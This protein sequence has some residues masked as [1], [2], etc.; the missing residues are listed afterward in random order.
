MKDSPRPLAAA[1]MVLVR[2]AYAADLPTPDDA[3]QAGSEPRRRA[4]LR[5]RRPPSSR[6]A[7]APRGRRRRLAR[8]ARR[9]ARRARRSAPRRRRRRRRRAAVSIALCGRWSRWPVEKR[10]IQLKIALERDVRLVRFEPGVLDFSLVAGGSPQTCRATDAAVAGMDRRALD[11][12]AVD[13]AGRADPA[14]R[15]E[16]ARESEQLTACRPHPLVRAM[17]D[18]VSRRANRRR[19]RRRGGGRR[20]RAERWRR[21]V[22]YDD[23]AYIE[24]EF[25]ERRMFMNGFHGLDEKGAGDAGQDGRRC[26]PSSTAAGR[27][28][29]GRRAGEGDAHRQGR[30][31]GIAIDPR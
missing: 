21:G 7:A 10:D 26:R 18:A 28:P 15:R 12:R 30:D 5:R 31:E 11:G 16:A 13:G 20:P 6:G 25:E 23:V 9:V 19:A 22:A 3:L 2:L 24:D 17:L 14:E 8:L 27:R 1:D 29:V 4:R